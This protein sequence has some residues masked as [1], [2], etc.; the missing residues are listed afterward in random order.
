MFGSTFTLTRRP[1][2]LR[3]SLRLFSTRNARSRSGSVFI[4]VLAFTVVIAFIIT[5][6][7]TCTV[8]HYSRAC[9]EANYAEAIDLADAGFNYELR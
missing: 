7:A 8:S 6:V 9:T 3:R 5:G 4:S 1:I 2:A